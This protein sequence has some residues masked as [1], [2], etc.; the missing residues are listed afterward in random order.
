MES[1][2]EQLKSVSEVLQF[3]GLV[4]FMRIFMG[5]R[6]A[7]MAR[8]LG[9]LTKNYVPVSSGREHTEAMRKLKARLIH[10]TELQLPNPELPYVLWTDTSGYSLGA[11]LL[12][13]GKRLGF[14]SKKMNPAQVR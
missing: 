11:V 2:P 10:Y 4:G 3:L 14:I 8:P 1:W 13:D 6:F 7:D 9:E 12:Q 5:T